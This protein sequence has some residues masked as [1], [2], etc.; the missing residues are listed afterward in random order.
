MHPD[1]RKSPRLLPVRDALVLRVLWR[2]V[3]LCH[4]AVRKSNPGQLCKSA[5]VHRHADVAGD[6][7]GR[8]QHRPGP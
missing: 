3:A 1:E 6:A 5:H 2:H 7:R 4:D 8:S